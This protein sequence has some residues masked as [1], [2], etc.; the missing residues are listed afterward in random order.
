[1]PH[2][3]ESQTAPSFDKYPGNLLRANAQGS[4]TEM[5]QGQ[6]GDGVQQEDEE[7][8]VV[9]HANVLRPTTNS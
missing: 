2:H 1:M 9:H 6:A 7:D 8:E 5:A 3:F 4:G